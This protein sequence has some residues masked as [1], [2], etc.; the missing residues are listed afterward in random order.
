MEEGEE[1][2]K[3]AVQ[4]KK[5]NG[6]SHILNSILSGAVVLY[7]TLLIQRPRPSKGLVCVLFVLIAAENACRP[8]KHKYGMAQR[9][10][11][12]G[13]Y[14][15]GAAL[16][17][18]LE[19]FHDSLAA[20]LI[21]EIAA[22]LL[23]R[24]MAI[25]KNPKARV[26]LINVICILLVLS[27]AVFIFGGDMIMRQTIEM[28]ESELQ[29]NP[30]YMQVA[31]SIDSLQSVSGSMPDEAVDIVIYILLMVL[32]LARMI[33]HVVGISVSQKKLKILLNIIR[34][35]YVPEILLGFLLM[36]IACSSIFLTVE[37]SIN[38]YGDALWY[39]FALVTTIGFGDIT[40]TSLIGRILSVF[41]GIYGIVVVAIIT[42][43]IVNFYGEMRK[44]GEK[45]PE[46]E[47]ELPETDE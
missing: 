9:I 37:D 33:L 41:L 46:D 2:L 43:V 42:S 8:A 24:I 34:E 10:C 17:L 6:D 1:P 40:A 25:L 19:S 29:E 45:K 4:K 11:S 18:I 23:S 47:K 36:I 12:A 27:I 44:I 35:T 7:A 26:I 30:E 28:D 14:L 32:I 15:A 20:A 39:A 16:I 3:A 21:V 22:I 38:E 13:L 5:R 31:V